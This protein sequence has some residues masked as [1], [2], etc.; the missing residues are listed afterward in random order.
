[1][2]AGTASIT[3]GVENYGASAYSTFSF[4]FLSSHVISAQKMGEGKEEIMDLC[5]SS[6]PIQP[7]STLN[8]THVTFT[9][10]KERL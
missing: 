2:N 3:L 4:P 9:Q 6:Y 5:Q 10:H 1:M 7:P 8:N